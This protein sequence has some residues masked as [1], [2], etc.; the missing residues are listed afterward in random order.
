MPNRHQAITWTNADP[1]HWRIY[2]TLGVH[3]LTLRTLRHG[4]TSKWYQK[5]LVASN[6]WSS[7]KLCYL[8]K[9]IKTQNFCDEKHKLSSVIP[10]TFF[11]VLLKG[12]IDNMS[13]FVQVMVWGNT[14]D[15]PLPEQWE[16]YLLW[17][18]TYPFYDKQIKPLIVSI[19]FQWYTTKSLKISLH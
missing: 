8:N 5:T 11:L 16:K 9:Y 17:I 3:E 4:F 1:V 6:W 15:K 19:I 13:P 14:G 18:I 12:P 10:N 2:A 7:Q